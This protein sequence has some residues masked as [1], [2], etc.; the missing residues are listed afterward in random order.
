MILCFNILKIHLLKAKAIMKV[1]RDELKK[2]YGT[3]GTDDL[4]ALKKNGG[5][6]ETAL[7][8]LEE[9][10]STRKPFE[11]EP[12]ERLKDVATKRDNKYRK[13]SIEL[14]IFLFIAFLLKTY[15]P[16]GL[17]RTCYYNVFRPYQYYIE[18]GIE[19]SQNGKYSQA[20]EALIIAREKEPQNYLVYTQLGVTYVRLD[21]IDKA[22]EYFEK[23][24]ALSPDLDSDAA[25]CMA[26]S[27]AY[28]WTGNSDMAKQ[29]LKKAIDLYE[30]DGKAQNAEDARQ[31]LKHIKKFSP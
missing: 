1:T 24:I 30:K 20:I 26:I 4:L 12:E 27:T 22:K 8:V 5:L 14:F 29:L 23:A 9:E 16:S 2:R 11:E 21:Q 25:A 15:F 18:K 6:T 31:A 10:L 13:W 19:L 7:S 28:L 17:L 3:L